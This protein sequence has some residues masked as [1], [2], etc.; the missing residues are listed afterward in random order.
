MAYQLKV[1]EQKVEAERLY[2][3]EGVPLK[4]IARRQGRH[5]NTIHLWSRDGD[6]KALRKK[7]IRAL[8]DIHYELP[9]RLLEV[10]KKSDE[11]TDKAL[12]AIAWILKL[13]KELGIDVSYPMSRPDNDKPKPK[14]L[15]D[16][17]VIELKER[18]LGVQ[19]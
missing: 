12:N 4:E 14:G 10:I 3:M 18:I 11:L 5:K 1:D 13:C 2:V 8:I 19:K 9:D 7:R 15:S 16:E 6:W 17:T